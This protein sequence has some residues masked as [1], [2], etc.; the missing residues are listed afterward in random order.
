MQQ[1]QHTETIKLFHNLFTSESVTPK[2]PLALHTVND[3][4][5]IRSTYARY[6]VLEFADILFSR[7]N[8]T[9]NQKRHSFINNAFNN[10]QKRNGN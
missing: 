8:T 3:Q 2:S 5:A 7:N 10:G 9:M 4:K 6:S 1:K